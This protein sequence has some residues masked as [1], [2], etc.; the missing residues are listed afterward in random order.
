[1]IKEYF[2]Q[3]WELILILL[4][5]AIM[6]RA[7]VFLDKSSIIRT[8]V[9]IAAIFLLSIVVFVEFYLAGE[10]MMRN[11]RIVLMA[12]RYSAT[13]FITAQ[14]IFTLIKKLRWFIFIP[15]IVLA[16]INIVSIFTGIVFTVNE[17]NV[18]IRGPL[19]LLPF[20]AVGVYCFFLIVILIKRSNKQ[21]T[22]IIPIVFLSLAFAS[23]MVLPFVFKSDYS[24]IFCTTIAIALFVYDVFSIIQL[25]KKDA[26]TGLLNRQ[27]YYADVGND[28]ESI[29]ALLSIDMNGLKAINDNEGHVAG[30]EALTTISLCFIRA[31]KQRQTGYRIGGDEF[32]IVCRKTSENEMIQLVERIKKYVSETKYSCS[33]GYGYSAD[34]KKSIVELLKES[35]EMMYAEKARYYSES[36]SE[37][38]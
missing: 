35:D 3:N 21:I 4:A 30:D 2:L 6:L 31:L 15:A 27:A 13:P 5:F 8:Y 17:D 24:Q 7:T 18:F 12:I 11:V 23:G 33:I 16:I 25:T 20:I 1:M 9:L 36:E 26:L 32:I 34:G 38:R 28:P 14:V 37:R 10:G 29:T 22:E 19:G